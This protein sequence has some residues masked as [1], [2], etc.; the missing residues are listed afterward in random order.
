MKTCFSEGNNLEIPLFLRGSFLSTKPPISEQFF[1]DPP[2]LCGN[3]QNKNEFVPYLGPCLAST[4]VA[5][6]VNS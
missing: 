5:I 6:L 2:P 3:F 4:D 1:H